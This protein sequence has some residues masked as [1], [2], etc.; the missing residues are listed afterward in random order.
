MS[1][2]ILALAGLATG[3]A[4]SF[5]VE[6]MSRTERQLMGSVPASARLRTR[7]SI[8]IVAIT[9][10]MF[11]AFS[12]AV[13]RFGVLETPEVQGSYNGRLF[14][15]AYHLALISL[16]VAATA[17]DFDC[18]MIPD[19]ITIPGMLLGVIGAAAAGEMQLCHL[20]VD[21]HY[22]IP[23]LRGPMI[24]DWYDAHR[25]W[26]GLAWSTAGLLT[27]AAV[28]WIARLISSRVLGQEAMGLGDVTLMAM[29][30]SFVG[31][32]GV[33]LV[34]LL[35]PV[36]GLTVGVLITMISGKTYLPYG[37]WL[38]LA[39]VFVLFNWGWIWR[40]TRGIFSDWLGLAILA[41]A[42]I[43]GF[44]ILL[45]LVRAYRAIPGRVRR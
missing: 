43:I 31:W 16:L 2:V 26:H 44:V 18:Y 12:F 11:V 23:H 41:A 38:S 25:S 45:G 9:V 34:F 27:G 24:P 39:A 14:R 13:F 20:W 8:A 35:A 22:A 36:A 30:G 5:W 1:P 4:L 3:I 28:T 33:I 19:Q 7:R 29:I 32:Q 10:L 21:W 42:G 15:L 6:R 17:T 37:P 40:L